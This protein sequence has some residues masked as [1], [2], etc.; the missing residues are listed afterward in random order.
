MEIKLNKRYIALVDDEDFERVNKYRWFYH[1]N[2]YARLTTK[3]GKE[4]KQINMHRFILNAPINMEVDHI[5]HNGL[6]NRRCNLRLCTHIQ[7]QQNS[8]KRLNTKY[9]Y[10]CVYF[11]KDKNKW[12]VRMKV[13]RKQIY[14]GYF[15]SELEGA[16][17][18]NNAAIKYFGE[19]AKLNIVG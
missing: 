18:Y 10:K 17:A 11:D 13:N 12:R 3:I 15:E 1:H 6:D 19:F 8:K 5:N 9:K 14:I 2:G 4:K 16:K 7:N